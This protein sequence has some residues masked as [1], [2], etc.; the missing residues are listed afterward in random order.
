[1]DCETTGL[2]TEKD[3]IIEVAVI[4]F[5]FDK[6]QQTFDSLIDPRREIPPSSIEIHN[7]TDEMVK[8]KP[9]IAQVLPEVIELIGK[10][11]IVGHGVQFDID[12]IRYAADRA[13]IRCTIEKNPVLDTLRLARLYGDSPINGLEQLRKHFNIRAEGAHRALSDV[14]V[15]I[16]VFKRL[17]ENFKTTEQVLTR[18]QRPVQLRMMPL[19]KHKGRPFREI[20]AQYLRWAASKDFDQDLMY[21]IRSELKRRKQGGGFSEASSPFRNL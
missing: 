5:T 6:H 3:A 18:L 15:N 21:S 8:G 14:I 20:P 17:V 12:L 9:P 16:E 13:G 7:I 4:V 1:V 11:P 2:D 10:H 19:G